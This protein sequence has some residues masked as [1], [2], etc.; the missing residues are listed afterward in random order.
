VSYYNAKLEPSEDITLI[1]WK[2]STTLGVDRVNLIEGISRHSMNR[3][4]YFE[5]MR[6]DILISDF[7]YFYRSMFF[8]KLNELKYK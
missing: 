2:V 6:K 4:I 5:R 8:E 7:F 3:K 1:P